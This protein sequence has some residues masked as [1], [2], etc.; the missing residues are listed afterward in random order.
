MCVIGFVLLLFCFV[1]GVEVMGGGKR[2]V[3]KI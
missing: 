2:I 3:N 1:G